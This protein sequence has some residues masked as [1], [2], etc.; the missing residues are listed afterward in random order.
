MGAHSRP[1]GYVFAPAAG[2]RTRVLRLAVPTAAVGAL[3]ITA[4]LV[5]AAVSG[6]PVPGLLGL[7]D[8]SEEQ[9]VSRAPADPGAGAAG[10]STRTAAVSDPARTSDD[11]DADE[12]ASQAQLAVAPAPTSAAPASTV[13]AAPTGSPTEPPGSTRA[14]TPGS[15]P[16]S[17]PGQTRTAPGRP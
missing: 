7:P 12:V 17:P 10:S 2:T 5:L 13:P 1:R 9:A 15:K 8:Q 14:A 3:A 4:T 16:A 6:A 11:A